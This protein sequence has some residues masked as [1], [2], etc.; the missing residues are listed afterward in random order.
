MNNYFTNTPLQVVDPCT[1]V[2]TPNQDQIDYYIKV[3]KE[4]IRFSIAILIIIWVAIIILIS[5]FTTKIDDE[6]QQLLFVF[7]LIMFFV[8]TS[9]ISYM[10]YSSYNTG[11]PSN[12]S[13]QKYQI[14]YQINTANPLVTIPFF[15]TI[16]P[17]HSK[18]L[19][20]LQESFP[21]LKILISS[22]P[23]P[24][25]H[26]MVITMT[27]LFIPFFKLS[28]KCHG[29]I[30]PKHHDHD[31]SFLYS[32]EFISDLIIKYSQLYNVTKVEWNNL[33]DVFIQSV[34]KY[35]LLYYWSTYFKVLII[36]SILFL[37]YVIFHII[38]NR[39][40]QQRLQRLRQ[41]RERR[42]LLQRGQQGQPP[43]LGPTSVNGG[44]TSQQPGSYLHTHPLTTCKPSA[45]TR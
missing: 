38:E 29:Q 24:N 18:K 3:Q 44:G 13:E 31:D 45:K 30:L 2:L 22:P 34:Y 35:R 17:L 33:N 10:V 37:I 11:H 14:N 9:G 19:L 41:Q 7:V 42:R 25:D 12:N 26:Q 27:T 6:E 4:N 39:N 21:E 36:L 32:A 20:L 1:I 8:I 23:Q 15:Y 28:A 5:K 16:Y 40:Y 43:P